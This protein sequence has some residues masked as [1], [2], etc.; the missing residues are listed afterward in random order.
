MGL[1]VLLQ[2]LRALEGLSAEITFVRLE[3]DMDP[4]MGCDMVAFYSS[5]ATAAPL[6][7]Q[8]EVVCALAANVTL[9]NVFLWSQR[10]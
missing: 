9:A 4:D 6:A 5:R 1:D 2:I 7:S 10:G 3:R 8:V